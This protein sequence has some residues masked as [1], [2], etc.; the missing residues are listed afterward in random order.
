MSAPKRAGA[1]ASF[2]GLAKL[3]KPS[4]AAKSSGSGLKREAQKQRQTEA[5]A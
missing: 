4:E 1:A 3:S 2:P 5:P